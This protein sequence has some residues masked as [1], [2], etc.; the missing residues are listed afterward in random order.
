MREIN[1]RAWN[2]YKKIMVYSN[3]DESADYWDGAYA[4]DVQIINGALSGEDFGPDH[5][6]PT[7]IWQQYTGLKDKNGKE[8]YEG[9]IVDSHAHIDN[10]YYF[11]EVVYSSDSCGLRFKPGTGIILCKNNADKGCFN[12]IGNIYENP[13]LLD[14]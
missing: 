9:D 1:F 12:I 14:R 3:E 6:C 4:S 5:G 13:E 10:D 7:Y 8:I 11:R 2:K